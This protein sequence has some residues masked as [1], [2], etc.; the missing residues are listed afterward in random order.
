MTVEVTEAQMLCLGLSFVGYDE[1]RNNRTHD[2]KNRD[3]FQKS[4]GV[5]PLVCSLIF[6]D[7]QV[8]ELGEAKVSKPKP[9]HFLLCMFW[10]K[11][12]QVESILS[13]IFGF[14]EE[15]ICKWIWTYARAIQALK[16]HKVSTY[17]IKLKLTTILSIICCLNIFN[18]FYDA[19]CMGWR[20]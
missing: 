9:N 20:S 3:R 4:Y 12:Y 14:H 17:T 5:S 15:T 11:R 19:D 13:V 7:I 18:L 8:L 2:N 6:S 16:S 10:L 1:E